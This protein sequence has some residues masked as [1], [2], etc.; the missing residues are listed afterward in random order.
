M[1]LSN[2]DGPKAPKSDISWEIG[3]QGEREGRYATKTKLGLEPGPRVPS[4]DHKCRAS[5]LCHKKGTRTGGNVHTQSL[6]ISEI[7]NCNHD[8]Q[9]RGPQGLGSCRVAPGGLLYAHEVSRE[10]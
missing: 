5:G 7:C 1:G 2:Q 6:G 3:K 9:L 8:H 10:P 4:R